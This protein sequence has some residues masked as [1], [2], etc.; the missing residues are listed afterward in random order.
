MYIQAIIKHVQHA[1]GHV[2]IAASAVRCSHRAT[3]EMD[4]HATYAR[5][6]VIR[7]N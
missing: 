5:Q 2:V 6:S 4:K 7:Y 1:A 3:P